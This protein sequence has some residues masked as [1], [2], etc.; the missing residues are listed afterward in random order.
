MSRVW[1]L[2]I[3][4]VSLFWLPERQQ[5]RGVKRERRTPPLPGRRV[6]RLWSNSGWGHTPPPAVRLA[7][8]PAGRLPIAQGWAPG[9]PRPALPGS[10]SGASPAAG[11]WAAG[12]A[13]REAERGGPSPPRRGGPQRQV[14][15]LETAPGS[16]A[17]H[18]SP[19]GGQ[20]TAPGR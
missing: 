15:A 14:R 16:R 8:E 17:V 6:R 11:Q 1:V 20:S 18:S 10:S 19:R 5:E 2:A 7:G 3:W 9:D 4:K 12:G 13:E